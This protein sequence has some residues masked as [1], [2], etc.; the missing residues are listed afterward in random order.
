MS[1]FVESVFFFKFYV[2]IQPNAYLQ[3]HTIPML[4]LFFKL[5]VIQLCVKSVL[6]KK[7]IVSKVSEQSRVF[8]LLYYSK[9]KNEVIQTSKKKKEAFTNTI[10]FERLLLS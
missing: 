2:T 1:N 9:E 6:C 8:L 3:N 4:S 10:E 5:R 7:L